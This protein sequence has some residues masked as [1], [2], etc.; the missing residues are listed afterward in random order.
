CLTVISVLMVS[1]NFTGAV[2]RS[3]SSPRSASAVPSNQPERFCCPLDTA[4]VR[5]P[6][7]TRA[8]NGVWLA[9]TAAVWSGLNPRVSPANREPPPPPPVRRPVTSTS[10]I[11]KSSNKRPRDCIVPP[12]GCFDRAGRSGESRTPVP[13]EVAP[14]DHAQ[15]LGGASPRQQ[16]ARVPEVALDRI[17]HGEPVRGEDPGGLVGDLHPPR[18]RDAH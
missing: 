14:D 12:V 15:D 7:A 13:V 9:N 11:L 17:L 16:K 4:R 5:I 1:P 2:N 6:W 18:P 3:R 8:P 10:P